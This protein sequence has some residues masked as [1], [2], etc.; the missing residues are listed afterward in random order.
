MTLGEVYPVFHVNIL[1][2]WHEPSGDDLR[3]EIPAPDPVVAEDG[4]IEYFV[5]KI[6]DHRLRH[7]KPQYLVKWK[8]YSAAEHAT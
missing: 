5:E 3:A 7:R 1:K 6:L 2:K 4:N 8:G